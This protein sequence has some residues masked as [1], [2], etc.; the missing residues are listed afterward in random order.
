MRR[1]LVV[2]WIAFLL[3]AILFAPSKLDS[4][5]LEMSKRLTLFDWPEPAL[6]GLWYATGTLL[7]I[8]AT[9]YFAERPQHRPHPVLVLV[10]SPWLGA[11]LLL[12][13]YALRRP[14]PTRE[15]WGWPWRLLRG[16]LVVE[17]VGFVLYGLI[18]GNLEALWSE[19]THRRFSSF[20]LVDSVTLLALLTF[21]RS[22]GVSQ[23][24][25][26]DR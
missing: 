24:P 19:V 18:A 16:V 6:C 4:D 25:V 1:L 23:L 20:L 8:H 5:V 10:A 7:F 22:A 11:L 15:P 9:Y 17:L 2:P 14:D 12:P 21:A 26:R 13:Y 3:F